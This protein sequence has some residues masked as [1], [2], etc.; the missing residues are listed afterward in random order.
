MDQTLY[1]IFTLHGSR[2]ALDAHLVRE[3]IWLPELT[4]LTILPR[5]MAGVV[6][7]RGHIVPVMDLGKRLG[8][9]A[10]TY[11]I[12]DQVI[13]F[14]RKGLVMGLIVNEVLDVCA[15]PTQEI[16]AIP[17]SEIGVDP[18]MRFMTHVATH[19]GG[20][21]MLLDIQTVIHDH[22]AVLEQIEEA[23]DQENQ[24]EVT[25]QTG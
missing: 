23:S 1:L 10:G 21:V 5:Y 3:I 16:E 7:H 22:Q 9:P 11:Q 12:S 2:Y 4:T 8:C 14:E 25:H 24:V 6:N 15:L 19:E 18:R 17:S 13:V 20:I